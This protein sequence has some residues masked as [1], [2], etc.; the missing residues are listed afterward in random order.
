[1]ALFQNTGMWCSGS[2][3]VFDSADTG[4]TPVIPVRAASEEPL[5]RF[6]FMSAMVKG[7]DKSGF[8]EAD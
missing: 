6:S 3:A 1:M 4:S 8:V 2:T 5:G 7:F